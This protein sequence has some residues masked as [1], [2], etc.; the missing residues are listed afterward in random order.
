[1]VFVLP[2][3]KASIMKLIYGIYPY[4]ISKFLD[5]VA[6]IIKLEYIIK[7]EL[8]FCNYFLSLYQQY[9]SGNG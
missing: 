7:C 9:R 8:F 1:M 5:K 3:A 6:I 2:D 4:L